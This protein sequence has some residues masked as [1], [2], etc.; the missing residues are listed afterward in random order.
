MYVRR[1]CGD[2]DKS[3]GSGNG[4]PGWCVKPWD[5]MLP[6]QACTERKEEEGLSPWG[7]LLPMEVKP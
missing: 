4:Q 7:A 5:K 3:G 2:D 6:R 1:P